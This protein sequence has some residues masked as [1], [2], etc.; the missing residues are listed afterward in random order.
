MRILA[1][2]CSESLHNPTRISEGSLSASSLYSVQNTLWIPVWISNHLWILIS[3]VTFQNDQCNNERFYPLSLSLYYNSAQYSFWD[4]FLYRSKDNV[5]NLE[6]LLSKDFF[7]RD[8]F[9]RRKSCFK[10]HCFPFQS[11]VRKFSA[12]EIIFPKV[13]SN[14]ETVSYRDLVFRYLG[15]QHIEGWID[16][17]I[18]G[19][20]FFES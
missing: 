5:T 10:R 8:I 20:R 15:P 4:N 6:T 3:R 11:V 14:Y 9:L 13:F 1:A 7:A 17:I 19:L 12:P 16:S 18:C 2:F